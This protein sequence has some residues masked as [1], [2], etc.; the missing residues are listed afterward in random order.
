[1]C[2]FFVCLE[3]TTQVELERITFLTPKSKLNGKVKIV[4]FI[5][6][7]IY[8]LVDV[9]HGLHCNSSS[10]FRVKNDRVHTNMP[11]PFRVVEPLDVS[12]PC[13]SLVI[14]IIDKELGI[15]Q[16][17]QR[18]N[19]PQVEVELIIYQI[20]QRSPFHFLSLCKHC[21]LPLLIRCQHV[22]YAGALIISAT[23][24]VLKNSQVVI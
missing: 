7:D 16:M 23:E 1:M 12:H 5:K 11:F 6:C 21:L 4:I 14:S 15:H 20:P 13:N 18:W 3:L 8:I 9:V 2:E 24:L 10:V 22:E 17:L 19:G